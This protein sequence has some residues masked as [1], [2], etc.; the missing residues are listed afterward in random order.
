MYSYNLSYALSKCETINFICMG[1]IV[2]LVEIL[3]KT[4]HS[5]DFKWLHPHNIGN[6]MR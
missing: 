6:F 2:L 5:M 1:K 4:E 3:Y